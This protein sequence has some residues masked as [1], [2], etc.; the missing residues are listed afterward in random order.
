M[1]PR[2][3]SFLVCSQS[4]V[5][6]PSPYA[7]QGQNNYGSTQRRPRP[8][9]WSPRVPEVTQGIGAGGGSHLTPSRESPGSPRW[10]PCHLAAG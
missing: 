6:D 10:A 5:G 8:T 2:N 1:C 3:F 7:C 9:P 4:S